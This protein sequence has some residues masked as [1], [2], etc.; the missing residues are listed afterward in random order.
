MNRV[1]IT[2]KNHPHYGAKGVLLRKKVEL[3]ASFVG[4]MKDKEPII[5]DEI[6]SDEGHRFFAETKDYKFILT[7]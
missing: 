2:S 4:K 1:Q 5:M 3:F 6:E 7:P